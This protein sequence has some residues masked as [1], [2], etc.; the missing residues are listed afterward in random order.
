MTKI[1][2]LSAI[3]LLIS[4]QCLQARELSAGVEEQEKLAAE[5]SGGV[6]ASWSD[7]WKKGDSNGYKSLFACPCRAPSWEH[8]PDVRRDRAGIAEYDWSAAEAA[9]KTP[10]QLL[11]E[12]ERYLKEFAKVEALDF[13]V[14]E[15]N[16]VEDGG[17]R[18]WLEAR[19]DLRGI[20]NAGGRR[21]D[22]GTLKILAAKIKGQWKIQEIHPGKMETV[23]GREAAFEDVTGKSGLQTVSVHPRLE[24]IRRG[25]Y[26]L[27]VADYDGDGYADM[28]VG[29]LGAG[30][31]FRN[32]GDGSFLETTAAA[33]LGK[34]TLVKSALFADMDNDGKPD[35]IL[36][37]FVK[38]GPKEGDKDAEKEL[39][40]YKNDG[41]GRFS[42]APV[43][44]VKKNKHDRAMSMAAGDFNSDGLLD[45]YVGYPGTR[46]FTDV[47]VDK[48]QRGL[49]HQAVYK[50]LGG[51][52]FE[53][54]DLEGPQAEGVVGEIIRPH[55]AVATDVNGDGKADIIVV[56]DSGRP[57]RL[58]LNRGDGKF[59]P[60]Q[61]QA[62]LSNAA[63]GMVAAIGDYD[64]DG[65]E[66]VYFTNIDLNAGH[67][68]IGAMRKAGVDA[69]EHEF[70]G[71]E[72]LSKIMQGNRLYRAH[73]GGAYDEATETAGVGW[74]GE[75]PAGA[76]WL[77][78]NNDG[79]LDLYV[80]NG[81][82]SADP[83]RDFSAQFVRG[84]V[85]GKS[86]LE[87][88]DSENPVMKH[89]QKDGASFAGYQR[90]RLFRNNGDG[91]FTEIGYA[92]GV[93]RL[94][95]GYVAATTDYDHDGWVDLV[96]R[97]TDPASM[98]RPYV[99]VTILR[100]KGLGGKKSL[101]VQL[102]ANAGSEV[103]ARVTVKAGGLSQFR[104]I[105]AVQGSVQSDPVAFF[106]L[107]D[108]AAA[109]IVQVQWPSGHVDQYK[110]VGAGR[111]QL[112][113]GETSVGRLADAHPESP[114]KFADKGR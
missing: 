5:V 13:Q 112:R 47:R 98:K 42:P 58:Y 36:Q 25:G 24:A 73:G 12:S 22:R 51:W 96:L 104:E 2:I 46:D 38:A 68:L 17:R 8:K 45:L 102:K 1:G 44:L 59:V 27:A 105:R 30:Q 95:D 74:A 101:A 90:N 66:D 109:E 29:G 50:N 82:W 14:A 3:G 53:E 72:R 49:A 110:N 108:A 54:Q 85:S 113:E 111:I 103:G 70:G 88:A 40:F 57:S 106:G 63:W 69:T 78:F 31:L 107:G 35:L 76:E 65:Q 11:S 39:V 15:V 33:G 67:R 23:V 52:S 93:D 32:Q 61:V 100:N 97:H 41:Y 16:R 64:N 71:I 9:S 19:F 7:T 80:T 94:E 26:A 34:D 89:L 4:A 99:P 92:A 83:K 62:G 114:L 6:L 81:L 21:N 56:D 84:E 91:T 48:G 55:S 86:G 18:A 87:A 28:Y 75:A 37:R 43:K 79:W 60:G 20:T 10:S 77:D